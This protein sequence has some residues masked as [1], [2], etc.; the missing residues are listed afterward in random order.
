[1]IEVVSIR[2]F[3]TPKNLNL[4]NMPDLY[5]IGHSTHPAE[6]FNE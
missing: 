5:T 3:T 2:L 6:K 1:M 4:N